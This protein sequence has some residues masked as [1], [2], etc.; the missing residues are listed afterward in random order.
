MEIKEPEQKTNE[1]PLKFYCR[2]VF[3]D[4]IL[5][6]TQL[7]I[8]EKEIE[9]LIMSTQLP[10]VFTDK[11]IPLEFQYELTH[12]LVKESYTEISW[13]IYHKHIPSSILLTF[14]LTENTVEKTVFVIIEIEF[15]KRELIPKEYYEKI[16]NSFPKI[17]AE[18]LQNIDK[19]LAD[20]IKNIY[21]YESKILNYPMEK[22]WNVLTNIHIR[23]SDLGAIKNLTFKSP[24]KEE[25]EFSFYVDEDNKFCKMKVIKIK[26]DKN[27][28]KW[29]ICTMPLEGPFDHYLQEWIFIKLNENQTFLGNGSKYKEHIKPDD[30]KKITETKKDIFKIIEDALKYG[31]AKNQKN[32]INQKDK[33][34][35]KTPEKK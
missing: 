33:T 5:R 22:I 31:D 10:Y 15:I 34:E 25:T 28:N 24:L 18:M 14:Q 11:P 8:E 27:S 3:P 9:R 35:E 20:N 30:F 16:N 19:E 23:M 13:E 17:C 12:N 21:H 32:N 6:V 4:T 26:C 7:L 29:T 2:Y 1:I